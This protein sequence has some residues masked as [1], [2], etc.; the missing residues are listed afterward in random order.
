MLISGTLESAR[1][2]L[3]G[4]VPLVT[5]VGTIGEAITDLGEADASRLGRVGALI[6]PG[7]AAARRAVEL[8]GAVAAVALAIAPVHGGHALLVGRATAEVPARAVRMT[9]LAIRTQQERVR[10][11]ARVVASASRDQAQV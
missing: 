5:A 9:S 6:E 11:R 8:V 10:T 3:V 7:L 1:R 2:T 4:A